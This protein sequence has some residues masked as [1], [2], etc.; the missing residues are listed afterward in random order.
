MSTQSYA[1]ASSPAAG[2]NLLYTLPDRL[3]QHFSTTL[4]LF[5]QL[6]ELPSL[7]LNVYWHLRNHEDAASIWLHEQNSGLLE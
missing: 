2:T 3:L 7:A 4:D 1:V 6:I 5:E